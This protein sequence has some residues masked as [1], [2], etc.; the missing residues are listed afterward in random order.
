[1]RKVLKLG[2]LGIIGILS[3]GVALATE[4]TNY[5]YDELGRLVNTSVSGTVNNGVAIATT[6]D[7]AGNRANQTVTGAASSSSSSSGSSSTGGSSS[8]GAVTITK[9]T[10]IF[11]SG[12]TT[13]FSEIL[14]NG[15]AVTCTTSGPNYGSVGTVFYA[16][17]IPFPCPH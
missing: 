14:S 16:P 8:G 4:N 12:S 3:V 9:A 11:V 13:G 1:M 2:F 6:Y 7:K 5:T 15:N 17:N 10:I